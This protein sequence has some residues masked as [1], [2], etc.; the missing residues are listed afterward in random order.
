MKN[1]KGFTLIELLV[2]VAI[3]G[4]LAS[5]AIPAFADYK[6]RA[7]NARA[8]SDLRNGV[9]AQEAYYPDH[10]EFAECV[11]QGCALVLPGFVLSEGVEIIFT[12][13]SGATDEQS[14]GG[15]SC[16]ERGDAVYAIDTL[17]KNGNIKVNHTFGSDRNCSE[18]I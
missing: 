14:M 8:L 13:P 4:I 2:V 12:R 1:Q 18:E 16:H 7:F 5:I 10:E 9:T 3:I 11:G 17:N 15:M 6:K